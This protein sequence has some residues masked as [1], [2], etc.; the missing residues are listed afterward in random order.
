MEILVYG[1]DIPVSLC[2]VR[3]AVLVILL[4]K[5]VS[6]SVS[7]QN[8]HEMLQ[9]EPLSQLLEEKWRKFAGPMF[10]FNFLGYL[11]Y[12]IIFTLIAYNKKDGKVSWLAQTVSELC[13]QTCADVS[14]VHHRL[15]F[16]SS[17]T[18]PGTCMFQASC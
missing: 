5:H 8:R 6:P 11:L 7:F 18:Y 1:S 12:L 3:A 13:G 17:T 4:V 10:L 2:P 9:K 15:R 16:S 14:S